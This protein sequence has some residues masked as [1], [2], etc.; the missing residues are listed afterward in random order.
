MIWKL[1]PTAGWSFSFTGGLIMEIGN[2]Y[3]LNA[4]YFNDFK[5]DKLMGNRES[6]QGIPSDRPCFYAIYDDNT[7]LYWLIPFSSNISKFKAIYQKKIDRYK[8]CDTIVF[9]NVLGHE[10]AF[11]IQNMCPVLPQY[12]KNEYI[13]SIASIPVKVDGVLE[14][15]L[16]TKSKRVLALQRKGI[17]LIFPDVLE[18]EKELIK[19]LGS[20]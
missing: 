12:I 16:I 8:K 7:S 1:Y 6:V 2:F 19:K 14:K 10:K 20:Q 17:K 13:D 18:I 15:E 4:S 3:F 9:G 11:L 5:D